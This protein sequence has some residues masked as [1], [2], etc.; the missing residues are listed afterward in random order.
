MIP[1]LFVLIIRFILALTI[2]GIGWNT[3]S[4]SECS[5]CLTLLCLF[6]NQS[7][8]RTERLLDNEDKKAEAE[9][10]ATH[11]LLLACFALLLFVII[12]CLSEISINPSYVEI[13]KSLHVFEILVFIFMPLVIWY[14]I[15]IQKAYRLRSSLL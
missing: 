7:I 1:F 3:F 12:S 11:F 13:G 2:G 5:I 8:L 15:N 10:K 14:T 4:A 9:E 6:I